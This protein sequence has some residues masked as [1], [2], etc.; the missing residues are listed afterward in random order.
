M[1]DALA[2]DRAS[3]SRTPLERVLN[4]FEDDWQNGQPP[5]LDAY[6]DL[7]PNQPDN[8]L[9][10]LVLIDLEYRLK[11]GEAARVEAYLR[12]FPGLAENRRFV[13]DLLRDCMLDGIL[14]VALDPDPIDQQGK[15]RFRGV[16]ILQFL[17]LVE[18]E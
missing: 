1:A 16:L 9:Q 2:D 7:C 17:T 4:R 13:L 8:L 11:R 12:R 18:G 5:S 10:E 6:L 15:G 3:D 14:Y